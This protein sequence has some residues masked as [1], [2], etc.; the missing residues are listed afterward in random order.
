M[1]VHKFDNFYKLQVNY[2][3]FRHDEPSGD[4]RFH[5]SLHFFTAWQVENG[6]F[7]IFGL[8]WGVTARAHST[9]TT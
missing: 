7:P 4:D 3:V 2:Y 5:L 8:E 1:N 9:L 6:G